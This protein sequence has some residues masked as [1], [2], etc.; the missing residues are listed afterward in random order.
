MVEN[1]RNRFFKLVELAN[2]FLAHNEHHAGGQFRIQQHADILHELLL[3]RVAAQNKQLLK[4]I[5]NEIDRAEVGVKQP[6]HRCGQRF[7]RR[8]GF[9][10]GGLQRGGQGFVQIVPPAHGQR[11]PVGTIETGRQSTL[12]QTGFA[13]TRHA[14]Y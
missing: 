5:E 1:G 14:V 12:H 11:Q 3:L 8:D 9:F 7:A 2:V 13:R 6:L 4:L 10:G